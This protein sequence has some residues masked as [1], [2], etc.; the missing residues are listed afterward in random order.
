MDG[1]RSIERIA[2]VLKGF[3][4]DIV[5]LQEVHRRRLFGVRQNQPKLLAQRLDMHSYFSSALRFRG[6]F[7]NTMLSRWPIERA[8]ATE[9]MNPNERKRPGLWLER[10]IVQRVKIESPLGP[11][12]VLNTHWSLDPLDRMLASVHVVALSD[13]AGPHVILCGDLNCGPDCQEVER[14]RK[15][16]FVDTGGSVMAPT[17][18][19][20]SPRSRIDYIWARGLRTV[21]HSTPSVAGS[22]HLPLVAKLTIE[23]DPAALPSGDMATD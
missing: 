23:T 17:F 20:N 7:G 22:D 12:G 3:A 19:A 1:V 16:G 8:H 2:D 15:A 13:W 6:G 5:C 4:P 14:L 18:P 21:S 10:R 9:L 11:L